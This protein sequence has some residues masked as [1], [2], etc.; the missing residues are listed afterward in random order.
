VYSPGSTKNWRWSEFRGLINLRYTRYTRASAK[1]TQQEE[2]T[3]RPIHLSAE[4]FA[5]SAEP[6]ASAPNLRLPI[7]RLAIFQ[8]MNADFKICWRKYIELIGMPRAFGSSIATSI[9]VTLIETSLK[10]LCDGQWWL[11]R[12]VAS[13]LAQNLFTEEF[14]HGKNM[15]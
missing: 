10:P 7:I 9:R 14:R 3:L 2:A 15:Q 5:F 4:S 1:V 11:S 12:D 8:A 13:L 6:L